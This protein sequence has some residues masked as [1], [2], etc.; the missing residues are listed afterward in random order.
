LTT[1]KNEL[2][3]KLAEAQEAVTTAETAKTEAET[4]KEEAEKAV[5]TAQ[6]EAAELKAEN[7]VNQ[8]IARIGDA[9]ESFKAMAVKNYAETEA[10]LKQLPL[11]VAATPV[12]EAVQPVKKTAAS[13]MLEIK[14]K[15]NQK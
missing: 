3:T 14:N 1:A 4:A 8:Y 12:P 5:E 7:L 11:N 10:V 15:L 2:E 6:A 9:K 13:I